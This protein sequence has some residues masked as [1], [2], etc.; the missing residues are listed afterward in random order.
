MYSCP[1]WRVSTQVQLVPQRPNHRTLVEETITCSFLPSACHIVSA[2]FILSEPLIGSNLHIVKVFIMM[3]FNQFHQKQWFSAPNFC[4]TS[5]KCQQLLRTQNAWISTVKMCQCSS[6]PLIDSQMRARLHMILQVHWNF[7]NTP[8]QP[9]QHFHF[10][11]GT[12]LQQG[13]FLE[14]WVLPTLIL[15]GEDI[16]NWAVGKTAGPRRWR[17][18]A[19][20][21]ALQL[22]HLGVQSPSLPEFIFFLNLSLWLT[23]YVHWH[24]E[25]IRIKH[26]ESSEEM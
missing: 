1:S 20:S 23:Y 22:V 26:S 3:L 25:E 15:P 11:Q 6:S 2:Q 17:L 24:F 19:Q 16:A 7:L 14:E 5:W 21:G 4:A 18:T 10:V 12:F 9:V 8:Y 13:C